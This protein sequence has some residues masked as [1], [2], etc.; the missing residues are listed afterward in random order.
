M[1]IFGSGRIP[2]SLIAGIAIILVGAAVAFWWLTKDRAVV[3]F[4]ELESAHLDAVSVELS[5][6]GIAHELDREAGVVK[7][8][9]QQ[10]QRARVAVMSSGNAFRDS[11]GFELFNGSDFGMTEFAQ[12][13]NYQR[14][15]EGELARTIS[16]LDEIKYARVHLVLPE[17]KLFRKN[18]Q[19]ARAAITVFLENGSKLTSAQISGLQRIASAA[20]P[21]LT[22]AN[23][24]VMDESGRILSV[25][26]DADDA[27]IAPG[28]RLGQKQEVERYLGE[29][30]RAVLTKALGAERF[31][32]SVDVAL[33]FSRKTTKR[34]RV[35]DVGA[36]GGVKRTKESERGDFDDMGGSERSKEIEYTLGHEIEQVEH[37]TGAIRQVQVGVIVDRDLANVDVEQLRELVAAA[38]GAD[39]ARGDKIAVV[40]H[41]VAVQRMLE[42]VE[43][44]AAPIPVPTESPTAVAQA[45]VSPWWWLGIAAL[46]AAIFAGFMGR[47]TFAARE[48]RRVQELRHRLHAWIEADRVEVQS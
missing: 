37:G 26:A 41:G 5:R 23:V 19:V 32:V 34:E 18:Q 39:F 12:K 29:K 44:D 35:L 47:R 40:R 16:A 17:N 36:G 6:A 43:R 28:G 30:V 20:V 48:Q 11:V 8:A 46:V 10:E 9:P 38:V 33:D 25:T 31:A 21:E 14:A 2:V 15:V 27:G 1:S 24:S 13:I 7:V 22:E 45:R 3:L 42:Q 4:N